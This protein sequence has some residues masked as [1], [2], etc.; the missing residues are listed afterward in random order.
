MTSEVLTTIT[1]FSLEAFILTESSS[2]NE[3]KSNRK[4]TFQEGD[5]SMLDSASGVS[6]TFGTNPE[7]GVDHAGAFRT[8]FSI[9]KE[10]NERK[11]LFC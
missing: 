9:L 8:S 11:C 6:Q 4:V 2:T 10:E 7:T 1:R 5:V 3:N